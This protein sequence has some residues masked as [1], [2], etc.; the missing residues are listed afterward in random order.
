MT[1]GVYETLENSSGF[2]WDDGNAP[3]VAERH[4]VQPGECEQVFFNEPF[5]VSQDEKH[6]TNESRWRALGR[7]GGDRWLFLVFT[8][9]GTLIRV[10]QAREMNRKERIL[11]AEIQAGVAKDSNV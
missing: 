9:R 5:V 6:S 7:T 1:A 10:L 2:D 11:Y 4:N 3:K 8:F